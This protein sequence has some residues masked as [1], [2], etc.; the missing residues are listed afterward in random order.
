VI[1]DVLVAGAGPAGAVLAY[2]L[3]EHGLQVLLVEK[4]SLPRYKACGGGLPFKTLQSLP[5]DAGPALDCEAR[6]SLLSFGGRPLL[7]A[8]IERATGWFAMRDRFDHFLAER[9]VRA[10]AQLWEAAT[11]R[12]V[13]L[14]ADHVVAQVDSRHAAGGTTA[15]R[16]QAR[17]VVGADGVHSRVARAVGLGAGRQTGLAIEAEVDVPA[18]ALEQQG[19]RATFDFGALGWGY[20]WIFPKTD[21][22]SVGVFRARPGRATGLRQ[23]LDRFLS[24]QPVLEHGRLLQVR[25]H[26]I[27]LGGTE[28]P[29]HRER[30]LV[31]GDAANLADP[32]LGEGIYYAVQ[33]AN[34]AAQVLLEAVAD[35]VGA[36]ARYTARVQAEITPQLRQARLLAGVVYRQPYL[37]SLLLSRS[38]RMQRLIFDAIRGN[39]GLRELNRRLA[40]SLPRILLQAA[41]GGTAQS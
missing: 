28:Q 40:V 5:F 8:P 11:V 39:T 20:G 10:G 3:A 15:G 14:Q 22:L 27:P 12:G 36:L 25:G 13:E 2:K 26:P 37:C 7:R 1:Y 18:A 4:A 34:V 38:A 41:R 17:F 33:S 6:G 19:G 21:H 29:L 35:G 31:V 9:A 16:L 23:H 24:S 32:W 30:A